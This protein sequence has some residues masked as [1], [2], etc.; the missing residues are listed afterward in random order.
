MTGLVGQRRK[1]G[2]DDVGSSYEVDSLLHRTLHE[3][4]PLVASLHLALGMR[5]LAATLLIHRLP[6]SHEGARSSIAL[7]KSLD[8]PLHSSDICI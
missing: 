1:A 4:G 7:R 5:G 3:D 2:S 6:S 8:A